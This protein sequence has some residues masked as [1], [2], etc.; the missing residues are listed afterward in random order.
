MKRIK[1]CNFVLLGIVAAFFA[2][3]LSLTS[4]EDAGTTEK[5]K[6]YDDTTKFKPCVING[7]T[8]DLYKYYYCEGSYIWVASSKHYSTTNLTYHVGKHD[9]SVILLNGDPFRRI[10]GNVVMENDSLVLIRKKL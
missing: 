3:S 5:F 10:Q 8:L 4:C 9:E 6:G 2:L 7:D 1:F